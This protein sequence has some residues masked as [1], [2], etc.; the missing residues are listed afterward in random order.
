MKTNNKKI[1][2]LINSIGNGVR[3]AYIEMHPHGFY[4][5]NKIHKSVK[6]YNRKKNEN[7]I[8]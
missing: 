5:V 6:N 2:N 4:C 8:D 1:K 3:E 7:L